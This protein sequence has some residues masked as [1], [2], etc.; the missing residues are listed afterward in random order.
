[1]FDELLSRKKQ[2]KTTERS[3]PREVD[4]VQRVKGGKKR[5]PHSSM[6]VN[7]FIWLQR[8]VLGCII[9]IG[10]GIIA[11][12]A[13]SLIMDFVDYSSGEPV[14]APSGLEDGESDLGAP[15]E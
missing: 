3:I 5:T 7:S 9:I 6:T 14:V 13:Q 2:S 15:A 11:L 12:E 10:V 4:A 1:M 8:V